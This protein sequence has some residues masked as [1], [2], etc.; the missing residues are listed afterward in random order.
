MIVINSLGCL[1]SLRCFHSRFFFF[2]VII[3]LVG[4]APNNGRYSW[5][6]S[7]CVSMFVARTKEKVFL[8]IAISKQR[9]I[10]IAGEKKHPTTSIALN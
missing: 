1:Y 2:F 5:L 8:G 9:K 10:A 4:D 6:R 3:I 7:I